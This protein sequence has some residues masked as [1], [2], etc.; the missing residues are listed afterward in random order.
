M[1]KTAIIQLIILTQNVLFASTES[2]HNEGVS[3]LSPM[4]DRAV[5]TEDF[6][7]VDVNQWALDKAI[8]LTLIQKYAQKSHINLSELIKS[9]LEFIEKIRKN[10]D[11]L[12]SEKKDTSEEF[13]KSAFPILSSNISAYKDQLYHFHK[14]ISTDI[15]LEENDQKYVEEIKKVLDML[16]KEFIG[17]KCMIISHLQYNV[18]LQSQASYRKFYLLESINETLP[19]GLKRGQFSCSLM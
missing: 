10:I 18:H 11:N 7:E 3:P 14:I 15:F 2:L 5:S 6:S 4:M 9:D 13:L 8:D 17:K 19:A 1:K 12:T 16:I